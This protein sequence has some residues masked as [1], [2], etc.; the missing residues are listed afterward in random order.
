MSA[1]ILDISRTAS[2]SLYAPY[3]SLVSKEDYSYI[4]T[5]WALFSIS[6]AAVFQCSPLMIIPAVKLMPYNRIF[7]KLMDKASVRATSYAN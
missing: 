5:N 4:N 7:K 1:E 6:P 2:A 3:Y